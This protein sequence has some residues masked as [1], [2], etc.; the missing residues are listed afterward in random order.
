M[1]LVNFLIDQLGHLINKVALQV[2][3]KRKFLP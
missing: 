1:D 3:P 2:A